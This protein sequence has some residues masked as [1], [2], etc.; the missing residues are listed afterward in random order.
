MIK[1]LMVIPE[2]E[3]CPPSNGG[4]LRIYHLLRELGRSFEVH[5]VT[6]Q[7]AVALANVPEVWSLPSTVRFYSPIDCPR[8]RDAFDL[9]PSRF[10]KALRYRWQRRSWQGPASAVFLD[11]AHLVERVLM[12]ERIDAVIFEH[13]EAMTLAPLIK[14]LQP[15]ANRILD[16]HNIDHRLV[17]QSLLKDPKNAVLAKEESRIKGIESGLVHEVNAFIACSDDDRDALLAMNGNMIRGF[18]VPNGVDTERLKF[19]PRLDTG[20]SAILLFCGSLD[21]GPNCDGLLWF[22]QEIWPI[23]S[24]QDRMIRM[25]VVGRGS[26][27]E[28]VRQNLEADPQIDFI[29]E[30][31]DV[32]PYYAKSHISIVPL[33]M[34]S[35]TRLKVLEAM[36]L[37]T[38]IVSTTIGAEGIDG[39]PDTHIRIADDPIAFADSVTHLLDNPAR[40]QEIARTARHLVE[41]VYDWRVVGATLCDVLTRLERTT[42]SA[43]FLQ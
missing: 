3:F 9:L 6:G 39:L 18:T 5:A 40:R 10:A 32:A 20:S 17:E 2:S 38:P 1:L 31:E 21:Y 8:P 4:S 19:S 13:I 7:S 26:P 42:A 24:P 30:V 41:S 28:A 14:R 34:G 33:R 22:I 37:G 15:K 16:A 23:L 43:S 11:L 27:P 12:N 35:G 25:Q 36:A 29:G